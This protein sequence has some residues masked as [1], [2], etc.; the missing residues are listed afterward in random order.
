MADL[1]AHLESQYDKSFCEHVSQRL[2]GKIDWETIQTELVLMGNFYLLAKE[3]RRVVKTP[4]V[5][6]SILKQFT[7]DVAQL[8]E[9]LERMVDDPYIL[10]AITLS[11]RKDG[12]FQK[13]TLQSKLRSI[14]SGK[15]KESLKKLEKLHSLLG[16]FKD[17]ADSIVE[18]NQA[19]LG[20]PPQLALENWISSVA[21]L[22]ETS[23]MRFTR[24]KYYP[25]L[26]YKSSCLDTLCEIMERLDSSVTREKIANKI[27]LYKRIPHKERL[28]KILEHTKN[29]F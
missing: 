24:G 27:D 16:H 1:I 4:K 23:G 21:G 10:D 18:V 14:R 19:S 11:H 9:T 28:E 5:A 13:I 12:N 6:A 25:G 20:S 29:L 8:E 15:N 2:K 7:K 22:F 26:G 17:I 3:T